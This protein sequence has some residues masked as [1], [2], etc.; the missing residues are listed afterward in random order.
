MRGVFL[1]FPTLTTSGEKTPLDNSGGVEAGSITGVNAGTFWP[2]V[3][4][5]KVLVRD[6]S[7]PGVVTALTRADAG[8]DEGV[9][10]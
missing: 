7:V 2:V 9:V 3:G 10:V 8:A 1:D 5:V 4:R 6:I